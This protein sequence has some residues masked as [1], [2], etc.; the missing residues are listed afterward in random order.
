MKTTQ[1]KWLLKNKQKRSH[2]AACRTLDRT[3][4]KGTIPVIPQCIV[5]FLY[6]LSLVAIIVSQKKRPIEHNSVE[7]EAD[8]FSLLI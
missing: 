2:E 1:S 6:V 4:E 3:K 5:I 7:P 8:P